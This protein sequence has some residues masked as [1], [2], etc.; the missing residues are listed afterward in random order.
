VVKILLVDDEEMITDMTVTMLKM[1]DY[2][3][4]GA[5]NS[6]EAFMLLETH[7]P[8]ILI[9]DINL[10]EEVDGFTLLKKGL[11]LNPKAQGI[12]LTGGD[13]TMEECLQ[14]GAKTMLKKPVNLEK[15]ISTI[16]EFS[17]HVNS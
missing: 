6:R 16:N 14:H 5:K 17:R 7:K 8:D 12:I 11:E 1:R 9:L 10:R 15:L 2:D 13:T 3:A 4:Y